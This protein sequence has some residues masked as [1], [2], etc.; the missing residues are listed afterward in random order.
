M[1]GGNVLNERTPCACPCPPRGL[2]RRGS[3]DYACGR[4]GCV[5]LQRGVRVGLAVGGEGGRSGCTVYVKTT[6][7]SPSPPPSSLRSQEVVYI[8]RRKQAGFAP[9]EQIALGNGSRGNKPQGWSG[10]RWGAEARASSSPASGQVLV[11]GLT[12]ELSCPFPTRLRDA[13]PEGVSCRGDSAP[14]EAVHVGRAGGEGGPGS[15]QHL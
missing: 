5:C 6:A 13:S 8:F 9:W 1:L 3:W 10:A 12:N 2:N 4:A 14:L 15:F 7:H 11:V